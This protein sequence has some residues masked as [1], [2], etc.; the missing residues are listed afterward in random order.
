[1]EQLIR[2]HAAISEKDFE[3]M[4]I[5]NRILWLSYLNRE[6]YFNAIYAVF[7]KIL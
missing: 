3:Q 5:N 6:A 1:M 2:F 4:Q 7:K